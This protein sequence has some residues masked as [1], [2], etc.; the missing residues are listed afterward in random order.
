MVRRVYPD[1]MQP[2]GL[3]SATRLAARLGVLANRFRETVYAVGYAAWATGQR[4]AAAIVPRLLAVC[5]ASHCPRDA[6]GPR[7][8]A[9]M[10]SRKRK[11][12]GTRMRV[13]T[14]VAQHY[15]TD[16]IVERC[17]GTR[18]LCVIKVGFSSV[19]RKRFDDRDDFLHAI[20]SALTHTSVLETPSADIINAC[21]HQQ[22][23]QVYGKF[24]DERIPRHTDVIGCDAAGSNLKHE[25]L[26]SAQHPRRAH[27]VFLCRTHGKKKV[28]EHGYSV[29][30]PTD[31]NMIRCQLSLSAEQLIAVRHNARLIHDEQVVVHVG[32]FH[33]LPC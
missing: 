12:D 29:I 5:S 20:G 18:E 33:V 26:M 17:A 2:V 7:M 8:D 13:T 16:T 4:Q 15:D 23:D 32:C 28:A 9:V 25:R 21:L 30:R 19:F 31:T 14:Q 22:V 6:C 3:E 1:T 27:I 10:F 24:V 11:Y